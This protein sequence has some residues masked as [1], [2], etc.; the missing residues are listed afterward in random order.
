MKNQ[1]VQDERV[2]AQGRKIQSDG[3]RILLAVLAVAVVVQ[4]VFL[5]APFE[6]Y[7]VEL[8]CFLG[9]T[10]YMIVRNIVAGNNLFGEGKGARLVPLVCS[11]VVGGAVTAVNGVLNYARYA[12]IYQE[13][14]VGFFV[15]V[16]GITFVSA[17]IVTFVVISGFG[18]LNSRRQARI[19][20][21]LDEDEQGE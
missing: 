14:G 21:R 2:V 19:R 7:A 10:V 3:F 12:G 18:F 17:A 15:A 4:Q 6:Q 5:D 9:M 1:A 11:L 13:S 20:K 16:L 8:I